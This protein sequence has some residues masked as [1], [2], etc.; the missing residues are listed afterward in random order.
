MDSTQAPKK[1]IK[2]GDL[3]CWERKPSYLAIVLQIYP[4]HGQMDIKWL[5]FQQGLQAKMY[6]DNFLLV[7]DQSTKEHY[8]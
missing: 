6:M 5:N 3:V 1:V 2:I 8:E 4:K 7:G